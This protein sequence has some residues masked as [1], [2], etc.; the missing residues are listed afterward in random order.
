[1]R[2]LRAEFAAQEHIARWQ[3]IVDHLVVAGEDIEERPFQPT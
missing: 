1:L 2:Q 3:R